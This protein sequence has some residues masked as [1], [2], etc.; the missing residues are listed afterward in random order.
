MYTQ[1]FLLRVSE[2]TEWEKPCAIGNLSC[3]WSVLP[4]GVTPP[5]RPS[6]DRMQNIVQ[7][8]DQ[9]DNGLVG[10][11]QPGDLIRWVWNVTE[12]L[13]LSLVLFLLSTISGNVH[14]FF[15]IK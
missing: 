9:R 2:S 6:Q 8:K 4:G 14:P 13:G 15:G 5:L 11:P 10:E 1:N 7:Q 12:N 3:L